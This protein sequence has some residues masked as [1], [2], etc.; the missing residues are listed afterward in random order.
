MNLNNYGTEYDP[1]S[2]RRRPK[3]SES[4]D[5]DAKCDKSGIQEIKTLDVA[6]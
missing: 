5:L 3:N 1:P 2:P 4:V 6:L